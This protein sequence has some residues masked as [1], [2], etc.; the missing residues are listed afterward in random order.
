[1]Q[2][3]ITY[4]ETQYYVVTRNVEMTEKEYAEYLKTGKYNQDIINEMSSE[5]DEFAFDSIG[6]CF[7]E[8]IPIES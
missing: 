6:N 8:I 3:Q 7:V 2:V 4:T 5:C 1:M